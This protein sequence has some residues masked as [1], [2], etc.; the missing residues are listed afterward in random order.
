[1]PTTPGYADVAFEMVL[2]GMTRPAYTTFGV[3]TSLTDPLA[4]AAAVDASANVAGSFYAMFDSSITF[5]DIRVSLGT[6]GS[7]DIIGVLAVNKVP[8]TSKGTVPPNCAVLVH[9]VTARGGRRGRGRMF[10]PWALGE[11]NVDEA[12]IID[13]PTLTDLNGKINMFRTTLNTNDVPMVLLH[14]PS[15]PGTT[16]PTVPGPPNLVTS[17]VVDKLVS[18]Q[19]RRL[20]RKG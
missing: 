4:V 19:K 20:G 10:L 5:T 3:D 14:Q 9:K 1:M 18:T 12:G 8:S 7:E 16:H 13:S 15:K 17:L 2:G 11:T 6:D